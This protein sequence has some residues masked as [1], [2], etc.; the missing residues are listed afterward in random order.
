MFKVR[1][2]NSFSFSNAKTTLWKALLGF[3]LKVGTVASGVVFAL[4]APAQIPTYDLVLR[5]ARIVDG[6]GKPAY[7]SDVAISG[8]A[9]VSIAPAITAD[10]RRIIDVG[11]Q[12]L[13]P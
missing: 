13:A 3:A 4:P 11:G 6:S 2:F 8:D 12:V 10:A 7:R 5:N 9:I 1:Y